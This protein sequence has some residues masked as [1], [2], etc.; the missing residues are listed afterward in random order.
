MKKKP[1]PLDMYTGSESAR[2]FFMV[3]GWNQAIKV[4][5]EDKKLP[6]MR[7]ILDVQGM[8]EY[9]IASGFNDAVESVWDVIFKYMDLAEL[10]SRSLTKKALRR[11]LN[12][13]DV[14]KLTD[15][16]EKVNDRRSELCE[17]E[18]L[19]HDES[20]EFKRLQFLAGLKRN[21]DIQE[22]YHGLEECHDTA[23]SKPD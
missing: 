16:W 3:S 13:S 11:F 15:S 21:I 22:L 9:G 14:K 12:D 4:A 1:N 23:V 6:E 17:K 8:D 10:S 19:S 20:F 5:Y 2:D 18:N 7:I